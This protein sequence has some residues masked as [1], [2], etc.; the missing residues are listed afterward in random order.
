MICCIDSSLD[1]Q[2]AG[3][4]DNEQDAGSLGNDQNAKPTNVPQSV[5]VR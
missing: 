4:F 2:D 1:E 5:H 3:S